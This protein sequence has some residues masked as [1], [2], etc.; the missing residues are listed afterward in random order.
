LANGEQPVVS[1]KAVAKLLKILDTSNFA[2][3]VQKQTIKT[4]FTTIG[5]Y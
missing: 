2:G 1:L 5:D 3:L 4:G